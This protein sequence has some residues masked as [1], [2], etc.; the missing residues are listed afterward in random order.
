[1]FQSCSV[2]SGISGICCRVTD[3]LI[4]ILKSYVGSTVFQTVSLMH[5]VFEI[6]VE[7]VHTDDVDGDV[8][9]VVMY[10]LVVG[11]NQSEIKLS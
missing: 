11:K 2:Q 4:L 8:V 10:F 5:K 6:L 9:M 7:V 3:S 1:M